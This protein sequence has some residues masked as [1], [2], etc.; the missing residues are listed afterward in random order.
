[1][2]TEAIGTS[3]SRS[4]PN[5]PRSG[6]LER[7]V[8]SADLAALLGRCRNSRSRGG[9][10]RSLGGNLLHGLPCSLHRR[11]LGNGFLGGGWLLGLGRLLRCRPFR[12]PTL[13][14]KGQSHR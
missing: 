8:S 13:R 10:L 6:L 5:F 7:I 12:R 14:V 4:S 2:L 3:S 9:F 1:M 11:F